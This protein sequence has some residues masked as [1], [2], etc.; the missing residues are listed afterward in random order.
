M[1]SEI[2]PSTREYQWVASIVDAVERQT[3]VRSGWNRRLFEEP[4]ER[5]GKAYMNGPMTLNRQDVLDPVLHAYD[6]T[7]PL[8]LAKTGHARFSA[9][10]VVHE[11]DHHQCDEGDDKA[12]DAV[13]HAAPENAVLTEGLAEVNS[14][15][16]IQAVIR[17]SGMEAEVPRIQDVLMPSLYPGYHAGVEQA[18]SG[19]STISG[20]SLDDVLATV[21]R[22]PIAQRYNAMAD[23]LIDARLDG[24][25]P[26]EHRS[27]IRLRLTEPLRERLGALRQFESAASLDPQAGADQARGYATRALR[28]VE[29]E[30]GSVERHYR[31][32]GEHAPRMPMSAQDRSL[33]EKIESYYGRSTADLETAHLR[34]LLD[35]GSDRGAG[36]GAAAGGGAAAGAAAAAS[37]VAWRSGVSRPGD[38]QVR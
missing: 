8:G 14:S 9:M 26:P 24:L 18:L 5:S 2:L 20:R 1:G 36:A 30:L 31:Q 12:P 33:V 19:L 34:Q 21:N 7:E 35:N 3:G 4:S 6:A 28:T 17:D 16:V 25:M 13:R 37:P 22:T 15:R 11:T 10:V 27:Q 38:G 29:R 32:Y 23:V